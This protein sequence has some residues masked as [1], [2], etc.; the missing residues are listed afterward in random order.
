M[1]AA[2]RVVYW[3]IVAPH[4]RG[5]QSVL[6][7]LPSTTIGA[8]SSLHP[9]LLPLKTVEDEVLAFP[10]PTLVP[11]ATLRELRTQQIDASMC[12]FSCCCSLLWSHSLYT[13]RGRRFGKSAG[14]Q[15]FLWYFFQGCVVPRAPV[16]L[17]CLISTTVCSEQVARAVGTEPR[18]RTAYH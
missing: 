8:V 3:E 12:A 15:V 16:A 2:A 7:L 18:V 5:C 17:L 10:S 4:R 1:H 14:Q 9:G 6:S 13:N 11:S